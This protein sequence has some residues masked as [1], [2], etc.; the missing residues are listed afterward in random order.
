MSAR[1][2][3]RAALL[4]VAAFYLL[5]AARWRVAGRDGTAWRNT[6]N[7][8]GQGYHGMLVGLFLHGNPA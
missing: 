8:D 1:P 3:T 2:W 7:G 4:F 5:A 6:I